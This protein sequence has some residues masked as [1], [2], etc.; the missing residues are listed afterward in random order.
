MKNWLLAV[1]A[2]GE[3]LTGLVLLGRLILV[4]LPSDKSSTPTEMKRDKQTMKT[5]RNFSKLIPH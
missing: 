5:H 4:K 2:A 1:A 3:A